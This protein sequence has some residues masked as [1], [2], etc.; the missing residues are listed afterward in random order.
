MPANGIVLKILPKLDKGDLVKLEKELNKSLKR[1]SR[2]FSRNMSGAVGVFNR[3]LRTGARMFGKGLMV[4]IKATGRSLR[5]Q[6]G[7]FS[8]FSIGAMA[9]NKATEN[10]E[11]A[12]TALDKHLKKADSIQSMS[13][14]LGVSA[15]DI[16]ALMQ[17][18]ERN[19]LSE[20]DIK[21]YLMSFR[22]K[23]NEE[24]LKK[25]STNL[26]EGQKNVNVLEAFKGNIRA[27]QRQYSEAQ[28]MIKNGDKELGLKN[29]AKVE[30]EFSE[31]YGGADYRVLQGDIDTEIGETPAAQ[32]N[33][34]L[35]DEAFRFGA[36]QNAEAIR[37]SQKSNTDNFKNLDTVLRAGASKDIAGQLWLR[38]QVTNMKE[39]RA[40]ELLEMSKFAKGEEAQASTAIVEQGLT[41]ALNAILPYVADLVEILRDIFNGNFK[42]G[43]DKFKTMVFEPRKNDP[44]EFGLVGFAEGKKRIKERLEKKEKARN[45]GLTTEEK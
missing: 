25:G 22:E 45:N 35:S 15:T 26:A 23:Q 38:Q 18:G 14:T 36:A 17:A 6:A 41:D 24:R 8:L 43:W 4:P 19:G 37:L 16:E 32:R 33:K 21:G 40:I 11:N 3:G 34:A 31:I 20:D 39:T 7:G 44:E 28:K 2:V 9:L 42:S 27:L 5:R 12:T 30:K 13:K 29:M 10:F 1:S